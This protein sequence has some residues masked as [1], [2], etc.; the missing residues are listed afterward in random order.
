M[1]TKR[2]LVVDDEL[3]MREFLAI[4]LERQGYEV[5]VAESAEAAITLLRDQPI[6][7][8]IS[9]VNMPGLSGLDLLA[10][11]KRQELPC[12]VLLITAY[13]TAEKAVE[14][15][16]LG[17]YD[18]IAKPFKVNEVTVLVQKALENQAL[19]SENQR[20]RQEVA[21]RRGFSSIIG[22]SKCMQDLYGLIEKVAVSNATVLIHG[23]SGTGKELVA[24]AIHANS[25]RRARAFVAINCSAIPETLL[26]SELFG[27]QR[28]AFTGADRDKAGLFEQAEGG[29]LFL[30][31]IGDLALSLQAKLLRVLQEREV[32]RIGGKVDIKVD[33]RMIAASNRDLAAMVRTGNFR[34]DLFF[35]LQVIDVRVPPLRER[36]EDIPLL[37]EHFYRRATGGAQW[38]PENITPEALQL[39][40]DYFFPGNVRELENLVER[41][42]VLGGNTISAASLPSGVTMGTSQH[43]GVGEGLIPAGGLDLE[44]LL[45]DLERQY[46]EA[47]LNLSKGV[48][49]R[50][51]DLLGLSFR[52]F[53]YRLAKFGMDDGESV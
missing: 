13:T 33:V 5:L 35:R 19:Q 23:E 22:K 43:R 8:V 21:E 29:S 12:A 30:D 32:R 15:M 6:D 47:S 36:S 18:Y 4:M 34:E 51:A 50:A 9:D 52:S 31:E 40:L 1:V 48:K 49:K 42:V 7:L 46:L 11:I 10:Q 53:R 3:S 2:L 28:G 25:L 17:A 41:A 37:I 44:S 27:Y 39:L 14:A 24:K 26:E 45:N 16:K 38:Q 20:L